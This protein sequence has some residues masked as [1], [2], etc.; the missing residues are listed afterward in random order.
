MP[1]LPPPIHPDSQAGR[2]RL[3]ALLIGGALLV[4]SALGA[5]A[6]FHSHRD[7]NQKQSQLVGLYQDAAQARRLQLLITDA[8]VSLRQWLLSGRVSDRDASL[9][10][11]DQLREKG[12]LLA[13]RLHEPLIERG[14]PPVGELLEHKLRQRDHAHALAEEAGIDHARNLIAGPTSRSVGRQMLGVLEELNEALRAEQAELDHALREG[15]AIGLVLIG[16]SSLAMLGLLLVS[17]GMLARRRRAAEQAGE[18][19]DRR[20]QDVATLFR[21]GELLQNSLTPEDIR[22]VVSHT[23]EQLLPDL[24]GAFYV[25]NNSRD[26]LD[27]LG[28]WGPGRLPPNLPEHLAPD[29]CWALKRGRLHGRGI[30]D[31][32]PCDHAEDDERLVLCVPMQARGEVYG[33]LQFYDDG[34]GLLAPSQMELAQALADGVSLA[35]ANLALREQLRNQALRDELTG[36]YNR[37]F[38][39]ETLPAMI[40]Q[41]ERRA[42]PISVLMLDL[43][44]FKQINDRYGHAIGDAVLRE[45]GGLLLSRV[46]R[47][48]VACRYGGEE[49][50]VLMPDCAAMDAMARA[51]ELCRMV[52][53]LRDEARS[54]LP[55]VTVSIGVATWPD[56]GEAMGRVIE[57]ADGALYRAKHAGRDR[58]M[59]AS[60]ATSP[61]EVPDLVG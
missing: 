43:D 2:R 40:S 34:T 54:T 27:V 16:T 25:F 45:V 18:A 49:I 33:L 60:A 19:M 52:R 17:V 22:R 35:L 55:P 51:D 30:G 26:R 41:A 23:A 1:S 15:Q 29:S 9:R 28:I 8:Q 13:V 20:G 44:N 50:I 57:A 5:A 58:A 39:D 31:S 10:G 38:L 11:S 53:A 36:L 24:S 42:A 21:M 59:I 47:M 14:L 61:A 46:R 32:L 56:H 48:D 12:R 7:L 6:A 3:P 4:I 37:R